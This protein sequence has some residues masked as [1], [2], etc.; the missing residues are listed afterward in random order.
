LGRF[1]AFGLVLLC[2][3]AG[4]GCGAGDGAPCAKDGDCLSG[5]ACVYKIADRC[6]STPTCQSRPTG[7][8]C[9]LIVSYCGCDGRTVGVGCD[10]P[11]GYAPAPV[12]GLSQS[13]TC[14]TGSKDVGAPCTDASQC[15]VS[16]LCAFP[17]DGGCTAQGTCQPEPS[18]SAPAGGRLDYYC[19]CGDRS[20]DTVAAACESPAT[21]ALEPVAGPRPGATCPVPDAG[22]D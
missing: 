11:A 17:V 1:A 12:G 4:P 8:I 22:V 13:M 19:G 14:P 5:S 6:A 16:Q 10:Q 3:I 21:F 15:G 9:G 7:L 18:E 20:G 2:G